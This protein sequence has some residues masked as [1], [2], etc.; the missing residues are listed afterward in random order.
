MDKLV[1]VSL[2]NY[3][4]LL[5]KT[6]YKK[7]TDVFNLLVLSYIQDILNCKN[8]YLDEEDYKVLI[9]ALY[10]LSESTCE[11][12]NVTNACV[13]NCD[14]NNSTTLLVESDVASLLE[15]I[16]GGVSS[17]YN[18]DKNTVYKFRL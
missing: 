8:S 10:Y 11:I 1:Y 14:C 16:T 4:N 2:I 7:Y 6:G 3:Y 17:T 5:E 13:N 9:N 12:P 18:I 15:L